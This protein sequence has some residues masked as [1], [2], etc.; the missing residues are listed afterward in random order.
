MPKWSKS[1][2]VCFAH[3]SGLAQQMPQPLLPNKQLLV[4]DEDLILVDIGDEFLNLV[5]LGVTYRHN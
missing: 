4:V 2:C 3:N 5:E 1:G